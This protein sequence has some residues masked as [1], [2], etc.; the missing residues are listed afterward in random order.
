MIESV[1]KQK[2]ILDY[3]QRWAMNCRIGWFLRRD[4]LSSLSW[5]II[6][7]FYNITLSC[8]HKVRSPYKE[9][10]LELKD[11]EESYQ[12]NYCEDCATESLQDKN[13]KKIAVYYNDEKV[14]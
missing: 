8:G 5:H 9:Y 11:G 4:D 7:E 1:E 10:I 6:D 12:G 2:R 14:E 3:L 13:C